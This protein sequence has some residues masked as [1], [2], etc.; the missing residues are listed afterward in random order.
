MKIKAFRKLTIIVLA[1]ARLRITTV[2]QN[3]RQPQ[4]YINDSVWFGS[5]GERRENAK[6]NE[7]VR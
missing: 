4:R 6:E 2:I 3:Q 5:K 7:R 1:C